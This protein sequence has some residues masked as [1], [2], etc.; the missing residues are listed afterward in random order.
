MERS[1]RSRASEE[2]RT[3]LA[4]MMFNP[5]FE[6]EWRGEITTRFSGP[7]HQDWRSRLPCR[8]ISARSQVVDPEGLVVLLFDLPFE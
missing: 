2:K 4:D 1:I 6:G 3:S 8:A 5:W 7:S